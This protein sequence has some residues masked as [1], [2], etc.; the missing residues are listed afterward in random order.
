MCWYLKVG[1][2]WWKQGC[3]S[4][5]VAVGLIF[6][7]SK[8]TWLFCEVGGKG[9]PP[10]SQVHAY[11]ISMLPAKMRD[12]NLKRFFCTLLRAAHHFTFLFCIQTE[13]LQNNFV[14][15]WE[16][17]GMLTDQN[18]GY[19][20]KLS[21]WRITAGSSFWPGL[22]CIP[23]LPYRCCILQAKRRLVQ[24]NFQVKLEP[25]LS[26]SRATILDTLNLRVYTGDQISLF[27]Q[28]KCLTA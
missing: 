27:S 23:K 8:P 19:W 17:L 3:P 28:I 7:H 20:F 6:G 26:I 12:I 21:F 9:V 10:D 22:F 1:G 18:A 25:S 16:Y 2:G 4:L 11:S 24:R 14:R 15:R 5:Q 13:W